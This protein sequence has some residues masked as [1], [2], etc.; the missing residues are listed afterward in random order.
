MRDMRRFASETLLMV[1]Y[2]Q[3]KADKLQM[4]LRGLR[5]GWSGVGGTFDPARP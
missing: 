1:V 5:H 4:L 3:Q 2:E